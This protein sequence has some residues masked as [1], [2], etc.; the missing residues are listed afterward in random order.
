MYIIGPDPY[1]KPQ[2]NI[3]PFGTTDIAFN[4]KLKRSNEIDDYFKERF[5][6]RRFSYTNNGRE[7]IRLALG[8]YN[9]SREDFVTILT[10]SSNY[11]ISSCVTYEIEKFCHWNR[12]AGKDTS[13]LF[14][15]HEF[16]YPV[17]GIDE[18]SKTGIPVIEDC[19]HSFFLGDIQRGVG[20]SGDFA[21]LS[22]PKMFPLQVGGLLVINRDKEPITES[23]IK[24]EIKQYVKNVLSFYIRS[25]SEIKER[26]LINYLF[27]REKYEDLGFRERFQLIPG[28]IPG[29]F[30]FRTDG[31]NLDL[32]A[33]KN[34]YY[35]HGIQ[36]SVF[37]GEEAFFLPCHQNL[38]ESDLLYF[39]EVMKSF[40]FKHQL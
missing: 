29:V 33:L 38:E 37:Y 25:E 36:C 23:T 26:R 15:N 39:V 9:L 4:A 16:G 28:I 20:V 19:A 17:E 34:Y 21:V 13:L 40:L 24:P 31:H 8:T 14:L 35:D 11:Y 27:L 12:I 32:P 1:L 6:G 5:P 30:M 22:F 3:S 10:S 18:F 7:A 2:Y